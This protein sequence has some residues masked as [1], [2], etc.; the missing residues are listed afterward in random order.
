VSKGISDSMDCDENLISKDDKIEYIENRRFTRTYRVPISITAGML[1]MFLV[2]F[3]LWK[4]IGKRIYD[5]LIIGKDEESRIA[6]WF[7]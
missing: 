7:V 2:V 5:D 4:S 3:L 1:W 6:A